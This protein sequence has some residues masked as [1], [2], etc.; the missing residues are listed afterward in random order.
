M[1]RPTYHFHP[2]PRYETDNDKAP[3]DKDNDDIEY[4]P[5]EIPFIDLDL[6]DPPD[7]GISSTTSSS[8]A[9]NVSIVEISSDDSQDDTEPLKKTGVC[10]HHPHLKQTTK[11]APVKQMVG[12]RRQAAPPKRF[13]QPAGQ[14]SVTSKQPYVINIV[15][16]I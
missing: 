12:L 3:A 13:G 11:T 9:G 16:Q 5:K 4:V 2:D 7:H 15:Y 14:K 1:N 6:Y 10:P 8:G